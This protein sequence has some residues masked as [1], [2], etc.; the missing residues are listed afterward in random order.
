[1]K[2]NLNIGSF[3]IPLVLLITI[4]AGCWSSNEIDEL[5][6]V[7]AISF[8]KGEETEAEM[9][10]REE[11]A[12]FPKR[13]LIT[14]TYQFINPMGSAGGNGHG[15]GDQ[16]PY[17]NF[18]QTGDSIHQVIRE[19]ALRRDRPIFSPHLKVIVIS[20]E[21]LKNLSLHQILDLY[22]RDNE[23][24]LSTYALTSKGKASET[25]EI[26]GAGDFPAMH[27]LGIT[28]ND[29]R[30]TKVVPSI[31]FTKLIGKMHSTS[32]FILQN[33]ASAN[34]EV[35][36]A[37]ATIINGKTKKW[38]GFLDEVD[39][40]GLM[41]LTGEAEGGVLK[42]ID[43]ETAKIVLFEINSM[44]RKVKSTLDGNKISFDVTIKAEGRLSENWVVEKSHDNEFLN[45]VEKAAEKKVEELV[46]NILEKIQTELHV[47][48][49]K[50]GEHLRIHHPK[51]WEKEKDDWDQTFSDVPITFNVDLTITDFGTV[52]SK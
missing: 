28:K 49:A 47:D 19:I 39:L 21:L 33:V 14:L 11:G 32:S 45:S 42:T 20:E 6:F 27:L 3:F 50:F 4:L 29:F 46:K 40:E 31:P 30:S 25:L 10:L 23:L 37:G 12:G 22:L 1:M 43:E 15:G 2:R 9:K 7:T 13:D 17:I 51:L 5:G 38:H 8:D 44:K 16:K 41:W 35:K 36:F 26:E 18:S 34:G 52:I 48:V 24:R